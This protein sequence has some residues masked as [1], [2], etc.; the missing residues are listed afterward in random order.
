M[1]LLLVRKLFTAE[2]TIGELSIDGV[3]ECLTLEDAVRDHKVPDVTAIPAGTYDVTIR[4]SPKF[5]RAMP[6]LGD[7]PGYTGVL[8]HWGNTAKDTSGCILVGRS[9]SKNF[10]GSSRAAFDALFEK[11]EK[12]SDDGQPISLSIEQNA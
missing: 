3:D 11:L 10:I 9:E 12:A 1:K 8:I 4:Y 7:V 2:S 6:R 5:K